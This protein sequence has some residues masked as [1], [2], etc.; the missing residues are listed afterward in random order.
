MSKTNAIFFA[1]II[2]P[3][4]PLLIEILFDRDDY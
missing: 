2:L 4:I 3:W 1:A